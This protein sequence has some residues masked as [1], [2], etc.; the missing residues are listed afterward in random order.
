MFK[1]FAWSVCWVTGSICLHFAGFFSSIEHFGWFRARLL[2]FLTEFSQH[3]EAIG[4]WKTTAT[5][6]T[7]GQTINCFAEWRQSK[8]ALRFESKSI[9][10]KGTQHKKN[11]LKT[12]NGKVC[13][14]FADGFSNLADC[15]EWIKLSTLY[16]VTRLWVLA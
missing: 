15:R 5:T 1:Y 6:T 2:S 12:K 16:R 14:F 10:H 8:K 3:N 13:V 9:E 7:D 11:K 4:Q